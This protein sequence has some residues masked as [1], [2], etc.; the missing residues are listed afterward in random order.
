[1]GSPPGFSLPVQTGSE[2][3]P[4]P[5]TMNTGIFSKVNWPECGAD[6]S[7]ADVVNGLELYVRLP[8]VSAQARRGVTSKLYLNE[9]VTSLER[10]N[11]TGVLSA[12][13]C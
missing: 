10:Q 1:M 13:I 8:C 7:N 2:I 11:G 3:R 9:S 6:P 5:C 4:A 12:R